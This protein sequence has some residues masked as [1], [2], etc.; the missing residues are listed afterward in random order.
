MYCNI[1]IYIVIVILVIILGDYHQQLLQH[2]LRKVEL[3][4]SR[5]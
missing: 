5:V 3:K 4:F 1:D 2:L